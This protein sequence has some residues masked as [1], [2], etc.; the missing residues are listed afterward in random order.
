M[1][2][3]AK[4]DVHAAL[5]RVAQQI[6]DAGGADGRVS[7]ADMQAKLEGL[8][9]TERALADMFFR[10]IDHRDHVSGSSVTERDVKAALEYAKEKMIDK[11]DLNNNGLSKS[12]ISQMSRTG[13]LAVQLAQELKAVKDTPLSGEAMAKKF[14]TMASGLYHISESDSAYSAFHLAKP[15]EGTST[16]DAIRASLN[17]PADVE[18]Y[19]DHAGT[20]FDYNIYE[21]GLDAGDAAK[22]QAL[23]SAMEAGLT[24]L[25][26]VEM[27]EQVVEGKMF[28]VG[29][30]PDGSIVGLSAD[31]VWT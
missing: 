17:L 6:V 24:N 25:T 15:A 3:V 9:G 14:E 8:Q 1:T 20:Y 23:R 27:G 5:A 12:E 16:L 26:V 7:R 22:F 13:K 29:T 10:F 31:R 2:R 30:A 28:L 19:E 21:S 11:Y 4:S 18:L